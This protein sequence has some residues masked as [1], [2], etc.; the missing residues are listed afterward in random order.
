MKEIMRALSTCKA[1]CKEM[2]ELKAEVAALRQELAEMR[3]SFESADAAKVEAMTDLRSE[4]A[5]REATNRQILDLI[6]DKHPH[7]VDSKVADGWM[8]RALTAERQ[9][10]KAREALKKYTDNDLSLRE[11]LPCGCREGY[12]SHGKKALREGENK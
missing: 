5:N 12:C 10:A 7:C 2:E 8:Q 3:K 1:E 4:K 9:L 6:A 11:Q